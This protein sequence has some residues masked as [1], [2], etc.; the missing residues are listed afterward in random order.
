MQIYNWLTGQDFKSKYANKSVGSK[1]FH[2][3]W[4]NSPIHLFIFSEDE[5]I[6]G[7]SDA[8]DDGSDALKAVDPLLTLRTLAPHVKHPGRKQLNAR[9]LAFPQTGKNDWIDHLI[10]IPHHP[11]LILNWGEKRILWRM[12]R[13]TYTFCVH[14]GM[15]SILDFLI[16][17]QY[18]AWCTFWSA[19][20]RQWYLSFSLGSANHRGNLWCSTPKG[21]LSFV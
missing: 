11:I 1:T 20:Y 16:W 2:T 19:V 21:E 10:S 15:G 17:A 12:P 5:V 4:P 6:A 9:I 18:K 13:R 14:F 8:E 7:E 3:A